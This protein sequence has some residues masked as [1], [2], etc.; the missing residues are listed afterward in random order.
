MTTLSRLC[1]LPDPAE[2]DRA[3]W[4]VRMGIGGRIIVGEDCGWDHY[5]CHNISICVT[6]LLTIRAYMWATDMKVLGLGFHLLDT[7]VAF[8][9]V[10]KLV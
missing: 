3:M 9:P 6:Y 7:D 5:Y 10:Y 8:R 2:I 1:W 4:V